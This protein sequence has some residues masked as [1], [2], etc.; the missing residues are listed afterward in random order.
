MTDRK[1][2]DSIGRGGG[3]DGKRGGAELRRE[4][5]A[6]LCGSRGIGCEN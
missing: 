4:R 3:S 5:A 2:V 6:L 1:G